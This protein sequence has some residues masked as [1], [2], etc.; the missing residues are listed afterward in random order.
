MLF[1]SPPGVQATLVSHLYCMNLP[2]G[3]SDHDIIL[4]GKLEFEVILD[5]ADT[6]RLPHSQ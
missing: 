4:Y 3:S 5:W 6:F 2:G 1:R